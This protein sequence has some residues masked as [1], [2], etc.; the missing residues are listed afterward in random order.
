MAERISA[1]AGNYN[2]GRFGQEGEVGVTLCE[3]PGLI[4]SQVAAWPDTLRA[5]GAKA[6]E[7]VGAKDAPGPG[8]ACENAGAA[9]LR[10]EPLK[11]WIFG[12]DTPTLG[13]TD[14]A[15]LDLSHSRT[16]LRIIGPQATTLLNRHLPLD[17]RDLSFPVGSVASSAFD[18]VG[19]TLWRSE[20][21]FEL[22]LPRG[23][24]LSLWQVLLLGAAQFGCQVI[25]KKARQD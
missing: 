18:H 4:L 24:A 19:V 22:F 3:M 9:V 16:H 15:V 7:A 5:V 23:F 13:A 10:I 8:R 6:A 25:D 20:A 17:L 1:L 11:F 2:P 12:A 14:G 21:G